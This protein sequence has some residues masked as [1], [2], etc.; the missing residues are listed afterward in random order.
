MKPSLILTTYN[1]P[2]YLEQALVALS[3]QTY[4]GFEVIIAD[5]GSTDTTRELIDRW[6]SSALPFSLKHFWQADDGF[7]VA[8]ARNGAIGLSEGDWLIFLDGDMVVDSRFIEA[9]VTM[10]AP[11]RLLFGGRL[12]WNK[13]STGPEK[14]YAPV[15]ESLGETFGGWLVQNFADQQHPT[16]DLV[17][18]AMASI[19]SRHCF[20]SLCFKTGSNF[21][22]S[23]SLIEKVNGFDTR[24]NGLSGEDGELFYRLLHAGAKPRSVLF[25]AIGRHLW[26]PENWQRA[27]EQRQKSLALARETRHMRKIRC[28]YG[29]NV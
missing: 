7:R 24:F 4:E 13:D 6:A 16:W 8:Q 9:H 21:S 23:R 17:F 26:H 27:G 11:D 19:V 18:N 3:Q 20:F 25:S 2:N 14:K 10:A 12:K 28:D 5:D 22:T 1:Q 29:L 15:T